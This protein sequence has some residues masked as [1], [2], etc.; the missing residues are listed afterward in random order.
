MK[1]VDRLITLI[2]LCIAF[3]IGYQI[4]N[5]YYL[6]TETD[7]NVFVQ[8]DLNENYDGLEDITTCINSDYSVCNDVVEEVDSRLPQDVKDAILATTVIEVIP[9]E[10]SDFM[11]Y[12]HDKPIAETNDSSI[13]Y[14]GITGFG[15]ADT[16][17]VYAMNNEYVL[18]HEIGHAYEYVYW[19][20]NQLAPADTSEWRF[21]YDHE[22]ITSY[23]ASDIREFYAEC[24]ATYF[25]DPAYLKAAAPVAYELLN[26]DLECY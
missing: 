3:V 13:S 14:A 24:F 23:G 16:T 22:F 5:I 19:T 21:S 26:N 4:L 1:L 11:N 2:S 9:G 10:M 17:V 7:I 12:M 25:L 18:F 8:K 15:F 20:Y 6:M